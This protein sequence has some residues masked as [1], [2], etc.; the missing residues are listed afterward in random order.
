MNYGIIGIRYVKS[1]KPLNYGGNLI[2]NFKLTFKAGKIVE[3]AV[4]NGVNDSLTHVDFMIGSA[5]LEIIGETA[6]G[7]KVQVFK[8]GNWVI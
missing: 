6:S 5:E 2:D 4:E 8:N 3:Y 1:K 7:E